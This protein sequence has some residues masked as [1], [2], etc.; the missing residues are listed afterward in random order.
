MSDGL[1]S[2]K[3]LAL[4]MRTRRRGVNLLLYWGIRAILEP[5]FLIYLRLRRVGCQHIPAEGPVILAANHRSF[6]DPFVIGTCLKRPAYFLAKQELFERP[7]WGRILNALGAFPLRRGKSDEQ[8]LETAELLLERGRPVMIFMEGTRVRWGPL[9]Q[10][11]R[12]AGRLALK[13]G[14]P[15]VPIAVAG[16]ENVRRGLMIRPRRVQIRCGRPLTFPTVEEPSSR[17]AGEV[18]ARI[19]P[20]IELQ[21]EALGGLPAVRRAAVVGAGSMGTA[22]AILLARAGVEVQLGCR[23]RAQADSLASGSASEYLPNYELPKQLA[24]KPLG[25][26]E[27]ASVDCVVLAVPSSGVP[28]AVESI[29][30][31]VPERASCLVLSKGLVA[32]LGVTASQYVAQRLRVRATAALGGPS[33]ASEALDASAAVV[34]A[35]GHADLADQLAKLLTRG[36]LRVEPTTDVIGTELAGCAKNAAA[37]AAACSVGS[38]KNAA[39]AAA[40]RVF[41]EIY[42]LAK[43]RGARPETFVGLAGSGD[44]V[45]T[46]LADQSRNRRAGELLAE[47]KTI[48]QIDQTLGGTAESLHSVPLL[49]EAFAAQSIPAPATNRLAALIRGQIDPK[50]WTQALNSHAARTQQAA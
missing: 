26:I 34:L 35:S 2:S 45:A 4:H 11:R 48:D 3:L 50:G 15:V 23:T 22:L 28:A 24:A 27:F 16:S 30:G 40:G 20:C 33:H 29:A 43:R 19:W 44:L 17:I 6:L 13:T 10:P 38:G 49:A 47:G 37:L 12:G 7:V 14:A 32:P 1:D 18:T 46:V 36:G 5:F 21:W 25:D 31:R 8:A 9:G 41:A 42:E 39:G